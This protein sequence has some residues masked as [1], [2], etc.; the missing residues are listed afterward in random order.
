MKKI[1][2]ILGPTASG[3]TSLGIKLSKKLNGEIVSADAFQIYRRM[4]IGTAKPTLAEQHQAVHHMIDI[5]DPREKYSAYQ[6][7]LDS[8]AVIDKIINKGKRPIIVG[9]SGFFLQT[10]LGDRQLSTSDNPDVDPKASIDNRIYDAFLIGLDMRRDLLYQRIDQRVDQMIKN[11]LVD[12]AEKIVD[13]PG[14]LPSK[15]AIGY[16]EFVDY[17]YGNKTL[18]DTIDDIKKDSRHYAKRQMTFFR[19]QFKDIFWFD[20]LELAKNEQKVY[21]ELKNRNQL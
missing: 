21:I 11:G 14:E 15:R 17:F 10:L 16:R 8:R 12:E 9:G 7:M 20:A 2:V 6:F 4:D 19:N 3:K 13:I 1:I 5:K 18:S